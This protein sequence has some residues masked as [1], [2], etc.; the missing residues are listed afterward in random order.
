MRQAIVPRKSI[1]VPPGPEEPK[2]KSPGGN[3]VAGT[4]KQH[5]TRCRRVARE[6]RD[7]E[8]AKHHARGCAAKNR[9][10]GEVLQIDDGEGHTIDRCAE[11][12]ESE[13]PTQRAEKSKETA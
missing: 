3:D 2:E 12:A 9:E 6:A 4:A 1:F 5:L 7:L 13:L 11:L 8:S 10:E